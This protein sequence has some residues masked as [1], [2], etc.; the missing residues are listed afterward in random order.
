[1]NRILSFGAFTA[2]ALLVLLL[3]I[4]PNKQVL[5]EIPL[6]TS[7]AGLSLESWSFER[8]YPETS[9]PIHSFQEA[10]QEHQAQ[11]LQ[12]SGSPTGE[13]ES[14]GP[15]NIGGRIL[16]LAFHPTD[17]NT[18]YA[19]SAGAGLWKTTTKGVG[20]TAW[21][22]VPTNFPV[23][24]VA[25]IAIDP[26]NP[27]HILIGTGETYGVGFARPGTENRLTRGTYGIGILQTNDGGQ[28]WTQVLDFDQDQIIGIQDLEMNPSNPLEVYAAT[29]LG[30]YKSVDGGNEW[31]LIF[32][33]SNCVDIEVDPND[34]EVVYLSHGNLNFDL[35]ITRSGLYKS[36][37][38]GE[39]F[40]ELVDPNLPSAW[41]GNAKLSIDPNNSTIIY[42]AVQDAFFNE[43]ANPPRGLFKST[44]AGESWTNIN[45]QD[46]ARFQ[47]WYSHDIA[48]NPS[49]S[50]EL[51]KVG[52]DAWKSANGGA[53]FERK[54]N[55]ALW[56]F[57]QISVDSVEGRPGYVHADI[58]AVY[59]H[60]LE[61]EKVFFATD[62]GVFSTTD[63]GTTF[64]TH[65]GGLQTTQFYANMSSSSTNPDLCMGGTQDN[66]TYIYRGEPSWYRVIGGDGMSAAIQAQNDQ[67]LFGSAQGLYLVKSTD[68]GFSFA[69][70][71]PDFIDGDRVAFSAPY[72]IAPSNDNIMYAGSLILYRSSNAAESW[73][74]TRNVAIDGFNR[75]V[76]IGISPF[77]PDIVFVA[78]A[79][80]P[81]TG[82]GS[83]KVFKSI[84]A[85]QTFSQMMG[86]PDRVCKDI[87]ID[88][89]DDRV[90]YLAFSGFGTD[91]VYKTIDGGDNWSSTGA[92]LPDVPTNTIAIDPLNTD[93]VY[94]GND[95]G[96]YH[97]TDA[98]LSWE[99]FSDA[100]PD[101]TMVMDLNISP[102]NRKLRIATHGRGIYQRDFVSFP[103]DINETSIAE[104]QLKIYPNPTSKWVNLEVELAASIPKASV[105]LLSISG[106]ALQQLYQGPLSLGANQL[107]WELSSNLPKG[108]YLLQLEMEGKLINKRLQLQ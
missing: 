68:G 73:L 22:H 63:G 106:Q 36:I 10:F 70:A 35:N 87:T 79:P 41:S 24:G 26:N 80:D 54:S 25:T 27:D 60:P 42:A 99:N 75:T 49:N 92:G 28:T 82:S 104:A 71:S 97:S 6:E 67:V 85:G 16:C 21:E 78:T 86:L 47:G 51:Y 89:N 61:P 50:E 56:T 19:G 74:P 17:P 1:M 100:L 52:I 18:I 30:V 105:R 9:I 38:G 72:E 33:K 91:H 59:Y 66:S 88:P 3:S 101:A 108:Q 58:H 77:D 23:I 48:I 44:D 65:N 29:T 31:N 12:K 46:I 4:H 95:L 7:G 45:Q 64:T 15:E 57:G 96:V 102:A 107:Q 94:V 20:R 103:L 43:S 40:I 13:W 39:S 14:L 34:G 83:A 81:F 76:K 55:W 8:S 84:D 69:N 90:V 11:L 53:L 98:G 2:F 62:G 93:D 5:P 32:I 37:N